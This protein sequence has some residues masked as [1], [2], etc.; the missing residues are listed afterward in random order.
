MLCGSSRADSEMPMPRGP[1]LLSD[2]AAR[3]AGRLP[4]AGTGSA[5]VR[6]RR[7]GLL[8]PWDG[9]HGGTA[10]AWGL[11]APAATKAGGDY[12]PEL[13]AA[14]GRHGRYHVTPP[15]P[16]PSGHWHS[17]TRGHV[18]ENFYRSTDVQPD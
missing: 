5:G 13:G 1:G 8:R 9:E 11:V 16:P 10:A 18:S 17:G 4:T 3:A 6:G 12:E 2:A 14:R 15:P 7:T